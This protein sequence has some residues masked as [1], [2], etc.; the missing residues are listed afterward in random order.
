MADFMNLTYIL[1][2]LLVDKSHCHVSK[3]AIIGS[4]LQPSNLYFQRPLRVHIH[5]CR[6]R[7]SETLARLERVVAALDAGK[8]NMGSDTQTGFLGSQKAGNLGTEEAKAAQGLLFQ[9]QV[10]DSILGSRQL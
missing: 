10:A 1:R 3:L 9:K 4:I 7:L 8:E 2:L 6:A 5:D